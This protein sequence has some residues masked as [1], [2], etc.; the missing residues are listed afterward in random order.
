[1]QSLCAEQVQPERLL[2]LLGHHD[3]LGSGPNPALPQLEPG[4]QQA[5]LGDQQ[6]AQQQQQQGRQTLDLVGI[7]RKAQGQARIQ[8]L[9]Q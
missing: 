8:Q 3:P 6:G 7:E 4:R 2:P 5:A 9:K 1:M